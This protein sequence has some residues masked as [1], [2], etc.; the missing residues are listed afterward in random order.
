MSAQPARAVATDPAREA[1]TAAV[2]ALRDEKSRLAQLE[3]ARERAR[4]ES[5][6]LPDRVA[7][8]EIELRKARADE[9]S[10]LAYEF[11]S[12]GDVSEVSPISACQKALDEARAEQ[13]RISRVENALDGELER[14]GVRLRRAEAAVNEALADVVIG[15]AAYAQLLEQHAAA[16][17]R[18]RSVKTVMRVIVQA[19][20]GFAP[21]ALIDK[22][23]MAEPLDIRVGYGVEDKFVGAWA[24]SLA[25]LLV[26][27]DAE[28]PS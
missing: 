1:L 24:D 13:E 7:N 5:W 21:Q 23:D 27:P 25:A 11:A 28:L 4:E 22:I 3:Q 20:C 18:L 12:G 2:T 14:A 10:R 9:D 16:W 26:D 17:Q 19:L 15:S 8:A 6:G